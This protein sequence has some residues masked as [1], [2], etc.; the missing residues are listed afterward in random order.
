MRPPRFS[1]S[2]SSALVLIVL[3]GTFAAS[4]AEAQRR[5]SDS[6]QVYLVPNVRNVITRSAIAATGALIVEVGHDYVLIETDPRTAAALDRR[7][8]TVLG[9]SNSRF[10]AMLFP[11]G[12]SAYHDYEE[13]VAELRQAAL[14]HPEIFSLFSIGTSYEGRTIWAGK[15]S[16]NVAVD[17]SEAEVLFVHHQHAREHLTVEQALYTLQMLTDEYASNPAITALVDGR[18]VWMVFDMNPD[19][20]EYDIATG[21]YRS[22]RKNRQANPGST[23]VGTDLNRN[24]GYRWGCCGGSGPTSGSQTYRGAAPFSAPET[25][26]VRDFVDSRVIGGVQ[27]ITAAIDFH[28]YAELIMW[29][30]GYT[31]SDVPTDM[32]PD[33]HE[34]FVTM[35]RE[36][37]AM[38]GYTPQQGSEL[39]ISD[40]TLRDWLYGAHGI[41]SYTFELYPGTSAEGGFY[42]PD[43]V[44]PV[45]TAR[46]R[47]A[48]VYLLDHAEC[49][50]RLTGKDA[51][52]CGGTRPVRTA[53]RG[54]AASAAIGGLAGD[55]NGYASGAN[56]FADDGVFAV[57][58]NSG[59]STSTSCTS[60]Y[61]DRHQYFNYGLTIPDGAA[62]RGIEVRLDA[63]VDSTSGSPRICVQL[64]GDGGAT[65]TAPQAT[66][67][68]TTREQTYTVGGAVERWGNAWSAADFSNANFRVR[69]TNVA[70]STSRDFALDWIGVSVTYQEPGTA[71]SE[72]IDPSDPTGPAPE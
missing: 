4:S 42:P 66:T 52:Y 68:L 22:W 25:Q 49:P 7:G 17:E 1:R 30:Y 72:P 11:S 3:L 16:D 37:A 19:G 41:L 6:T 5:P 53:L 59:R 15:I 40:G 12:D 27:Q 28:T 71:S 46:N 43:E 60:T 26:V 44:I 69:L 21:T 64:S 9:A 47:D 58:V 51:Q 34:V 31:Y 32:V 13:M 33:D 8:L 20:G 36:M 50:Y 48:I 54:P 29:P 10:Q 55:N 56:A 24:W 38:T 23:S 62:I 39:Y 18:E 57:D 61:K 67:I 14:D 70:S 65:W 45:Q 35:G 63:R 2:T